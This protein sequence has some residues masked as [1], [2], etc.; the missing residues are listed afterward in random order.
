M[1]KAIDQSTMDYRP[2]N[3]GLFL[4]CVTILLIIFPSLA[5]AQQYDLRKSIQ[6]IISASD[7]KVGVAIMG[8]ENKDT[9]SVDGRTRC[10]MQSVYKL[11]L[12]MAVLKQVDLGKLSLEQKIHIAKKDLLPNTWSP[13]Q[14]KYPEGNVDV[15]LSEILM[16]TVSQSD[17]SGCDILFRLLGGPSN[18][19]KFIHSLGVRGMA[20]ATTEEQMH[21]DWNVQFTN[22]SEPL[23][24]VQLLQLI[25]EG[26]V[27]SS[28]SN[29]FL[30]KIMTETTTGPNRIKGLLPKDAM[31]AHKTGTSGPN[32]EGV[33]A[34]I[35]D[36]GIVTLPNG[37]H[38]AIAAFMLNSKS[39]P[40]KLEAVI[41]AIAK[42]AWDYYSK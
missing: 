19:E 24:M 35:N 4:T 40:K 41:A 38:Y 17:N 8:L 16:Y 15:P 31:V 3:Y 32:E 29:E 37:K 42:S 26:K 18:V 1:I 36:V 33:T 27:L 13:L 21:A 25:H 28:S 6:D 7:E 20:I 11:P 34:A 2:T 23:A 30:L 22:W 39:D 5:P 9:V 12:G 10:P 14:K